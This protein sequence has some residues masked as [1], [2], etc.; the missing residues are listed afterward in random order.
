MFALLVVAPAIS[1]GEFPGGD[2]LACRSDLAELP[3]FGIPEPFLAACT[4]TTT[5]PT[6]GG[7]STT[8]T[9]STPGSGTCIDFG[10]G[11]QCGSTTNYCACYRPQFASCGN[12][13]CI[14]DC[15]AAG[16]DSITCKLECRC[17]IIP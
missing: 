10:Y 16:G 9:C 5:C 4:A 13:Y 2:S 14:C 8:L 17:P 3:D 11:V 7:G 1:A 12:E 15:F 6:A